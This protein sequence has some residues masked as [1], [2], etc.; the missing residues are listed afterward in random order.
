[1]PTRRLLV[2]PLAAALVLLAGVHDEALADRKS[3]AKK[4]TDTLAD[5]KS[6]AKAKANALG[7]LAKIGQIQKVVI[8]DAV[9]LML[10][11][12]D[13]KD[14]TVRAAAARAVGM[15]D[16]DPKDAVPKLVKM[17]N[18]DKDEAVKVAAAQGL[19]AM[20]PAAKESVKDLR[21]VAKDADPKGKLS[22][23]AKD[24][25]KSV[26]PKKPA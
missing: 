25:L 18:D 26:V 21:K 10:A 1:M 22:R 12:L 7:E 17:L 24:A 15:I 20:G 19:N 3:D 4:H 23:A 16:P 13:D 5:K 9:P 8:K 14:A 2:V 6:D 11:A